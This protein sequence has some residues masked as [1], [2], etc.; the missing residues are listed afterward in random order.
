MSKSTDLIQGPLARQLLLFALPLAATG[1]LQ[2]LFNAAD[3]AIVGRFAGKDAMAAVG[4]NSPLIGLMVNLFVGISLGANVVIAQGLGQRNE[5][6]VSEA[7]HTSVLVALIGGVGFSLL[8]QL[9]MRPVLELLSV[10]PEVMGLSALY[11]RIYICGFPVIFLYNFESS[12]FRSQGD[13]N[14]P[15]I[16][17]AVSGVLNVGLN[18]FFVL[19]LGMTVDGVAL[20]TVIANAV[21]AGI[22]FQLLRRSRHAIRLDVK[23]LRIHREALRRILRIGIP[24]GIQGMIFSL[25]NICIQSAINSLGTVVMAGSSAAFNLEIFAFYVLNSFGQTCTTFTGQNFGAGKLERCR[26]VLRYCVGLD[27]AFTAVICGLILLNGHGLLH[28]FTT[29]PQVVASGYTRLCYIFSAYIF[30]ILLEVMSGYLRGF[31][32]SLLPAAAALI[33]V[34]GVR[35]LWIYTVFPHYRTFASIMIIY[36]ISLGITAAVLWLIFAVQRR[37][38]YRQVGQV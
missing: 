7:V 9:F 28:L 25:A 26:R 30:S 6:A 19:A 8:G 11:L 16:V 15:L 2:Q 22:L 10:P 32:R 23:R 38:M 12:I 18:L 17:L 13:T 5:K 35:I 24:A 37:S 27:I 31:G 4:S 20:A 33:G 36:P 21:S 3:V 1:I 34:C 29:D 14:T